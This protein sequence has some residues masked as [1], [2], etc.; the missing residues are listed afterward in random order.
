MNFEEFKNFYALTMMFYQRIEHDVK[1][2]YAFM[3]NG[4]AGD[5]FDNIE[6][7]TLGTMIR[8]LEKLDYSDNKPFIS[9]DDYRFLK[10]ICDRRNYWAH[11]AF[12]GFI[13]EEDPL[14][15][16]EYIDICH[17]LEKDY[18]EV[19]KASDILEKMRVECCEKYGR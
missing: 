14:I 12:I 19:E 10:K 3:L 9:K 8:T 7:E 1:L 13:Y 17:S 2:I 5:N 4:D 11:Q 15:S 18:R 16:K 6:N